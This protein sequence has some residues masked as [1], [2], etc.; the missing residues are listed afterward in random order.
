MVRQ[1][2]DDLERVVGDIGSLNSKLVLLAGRPRSGKSALLGKL[3]E[4][5]QVQ[6]LNVGVT[7]GR[8]LLSLSKARRNLKVSELFKDRA[9]STSANGILLVDNI[10]LLF[11]RTLLVSTL[12]L[13]KSQ[14]RVRRVVAVW[15]GEFRDDR[16]SYAVSGHPEYQDHSTEGVVIFKVS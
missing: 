12:D 7:L 15:P 4:R 8:D 11:D 10:E 1:M 14:S 6:V 9:D 2:I 5:M 16:L 13:L 3:S